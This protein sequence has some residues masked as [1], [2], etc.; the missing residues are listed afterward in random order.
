MVLAFIQDS[1]FQVRSLPNKEERKLWLRCQN[2]DRSCNRL[3][4]KRVDLGKREDVAELQLLPRH[5]AHVNRQTLGYQP[6]FGPV[7]VRIAMCKCFSRE[8]REKESSSP[9][10]TYLALS[11]LIGT[12]M[13]HS[14][15]YSSLFGKSIKS[16]KNPVSSQALRLG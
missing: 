15:K 1:K 6:H 4:D 12:L 7:I 3:T 2:C 10:W 16:T 14:G 5:L 8:L 11:T 13:S 9:H